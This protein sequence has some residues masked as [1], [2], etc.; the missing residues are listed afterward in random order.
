MKLANIFFVMICSFLFFACLE[1]GE[2][3]VTQ[4]DNRIMVKATEEGTL[5]Y[6]VKQAEFYF[7]QGVDLP[8]DKFEGYRSVTFTDESLILDDG[9]QKL[10]LGV[11]SD[12]VSPE[13]K[14]TF[15]PA[16]G[17]SSFSGK[18]YDSRFLLTDYKSGTD[19]GRVT[20]WN[21]DIDV[22]WVPCKCRLS[23]SDDSDCNSGGNGSG[24]CETYTG[25]E[26]GPVVTEQRC[27][28][29]CKKEQGYYACCTQ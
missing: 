19:A 6:S 3:S 26:F 22:S 5:L 12:P 10:L 21:P 1:R 2:A 11:K 17:I 7:L 8:V 29:T 14:G 27:K 16:N 25:G 24:G 4:N 28:V 18:L 23:G 13:F 9:S 15:L 20:G